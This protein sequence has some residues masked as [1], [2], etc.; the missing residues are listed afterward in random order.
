MNIEQEG[1]SE[2]SLLVQA[3]YIWC[4]YPR[5]WYQIQYRPTLILSWI[6]C[7]ICIVFVLLQ[8]FNVQM[9]IFSSTC[10]DLAL[11]RLTQI[12]S[13]KT[14]FITAAPCQTTFLREDVSLLQVLHLLAVDLPWCPTTVSFNMCVQ[15]NIIS[16][17]RVNI[18]LCCS[19]R[20]VVQQLETYKKIMI[21]CPHPSKNMLRPPHHLHSSLYKT[22]A[23]CFI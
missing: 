23:T 4:T 2:I 11:C 17:K 22:Q 3:S 20:W 8:A 14:L 13:L 16:S 21:T 10:V 12:I 1:I 6:N 5:R 7:P 9:K 18:L 15:E 19:L